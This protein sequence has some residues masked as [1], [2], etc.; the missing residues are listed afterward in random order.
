MKY[1]KWTV[2]FLPILNGFSMHIICSVALPKDTIL[3]RYSFGLH[4]PG[5]CCFSLNAD[6]DFLSIRWYSTECSTNK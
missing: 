3:L 2:Q 1:I 6:I 5:K 4:S